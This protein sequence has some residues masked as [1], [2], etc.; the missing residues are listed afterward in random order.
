MTSPLCFGHAEVRLSERQILVDG[1]PVFVGARAFEVLSLLIAHRERVVSKNELLEAV[2]PGLVVEENNLQVQ[3]ST[4][5]KILGPGAIATVSGQGYQFTAHLD[6]ERGTLRDAGSPRTAQEAALSAA[7]Q[8]SAPGTPLDAG[9]PRPESGT[10]RRA[11]WL[12]VG[13]AILLAIGIGAWALL[14]AKPEA[15]ALASV[16]TNTRRPP[17]QRPPAHS[18]AVLPFVNNTGDPTQDYFSDGLSEEL[19]NSLSKIRD[20]Q[21]AAGTSSV[22]FKGKDTK[23]A[24]IGRE[25]NVASVLEGSV[26]KDGSHVRIT[27]LLIDTATGFLVWSQSYDRDLK[28]VLK[29]QTEIATAVTKTLQ[30]TLADAG[31]TIELGGTQNPQA[32]DAYLRGMRWR[33]NMHTQEDFS[34]AI[35]EFSEAIRLD[36]RFAKAYALKSIF[37]TTSADYVPDSGV[38]KIFEQARATAEQAVT[39]TPGLGEAHTALALVLQRGFLDFSR[40]A[41]EYDRALALSPG[42]ARVMAF[43]ARFFAEMGRA[44]E[45]VA[46]VHRAVALDPL[47]APTHSTAGEA[48]AAAHRYGEAIREFDRALSLNPQHQY[49][50][51]SRGLAYLALGAVEPAR[52]SCATPPID[53]ET[54]LCLAIIY[55]KLQQREDAQGE[56]AALEA[57]QG[58]AAAFQYAEIYAQWGDVPKALDSI[59]KAYQRKDS[60]L[61]T[62]KVDY[63][64]DP[65]RKELRFQKIER[66]LAFPG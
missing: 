51:A 26:R 49:A 44:D 28:D 48:L 12:A 66:E 43:T 56:L 8:S 18:V 16:G 2:W 55:D 50:A 41:V 1:R 29:L 39:L 63:L 38:R 17:V 22:A 13:L 45:A 19:L 23:I 40:A 21:V 42:D 36:P 27:A 64:L 30:A 14:R 60:G 10:V 5:R 58:A 52:Q 34:A 33:G 54:H 4:L 20:L 24:E 59:E 31:A 47:S 3:I 32:L 57:E 37:L 9:A 53:W 65:L 15:A 25:L 46:I 6:S 61:V 62:L 7:Q 35:G 11:A